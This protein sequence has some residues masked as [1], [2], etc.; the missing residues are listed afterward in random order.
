VTSPS[1]HIYKLNSW[2]SWQARTCTCPKSPIAGDANVQD[3][4]FPGLAFWLIPRTT[5]AV[6]AVW[7]AV[8]LILSSVCL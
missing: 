1:D 4:H 6:H 2:E 3:L 8:V 5:A 7:S